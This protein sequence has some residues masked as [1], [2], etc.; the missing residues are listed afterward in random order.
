VTVLDTLS[1]EVLDTLAHEVRSASKVDV[2]I[3]EDVLV[4][5]AP[6]GARCEIWVDWLDLDDPFCL[7]LNGP[8]VPLRLYGRT[9]RDLYARLKLAARTIPTLNTL[10]TFNKEKR[11]W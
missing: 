8:C 1:H 11:S 7:E 2:C 4:L 5:D 6:D 3:R 9:M 10:F